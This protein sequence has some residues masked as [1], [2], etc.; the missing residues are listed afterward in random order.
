MATVT[1]YKTHIKT[2]NLQYHMGSEQLILKKLNE[3]KSELDYLKEHI[4]DVDMVLTEDDRESIQ[5]AR[6]DLKKGRTKRL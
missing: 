4:I 2:E 5:A 1:G 6:E 3:I